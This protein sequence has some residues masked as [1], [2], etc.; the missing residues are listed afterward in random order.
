MFPIKP[1]RTSHL[2]DF[3]GVEYKC[4]RQDD[5]KITEITEVMAR[6]F[7]C[8]LGKCK[9]WN[10]ELGDYYYMRVQYTKNGSRKHP[11][12]NT[13][14]EEEYYF[15]NE[16]EGNEFIKSLQEK[17]D[18]LKRLYYWNIL[19][20]SSSKAGPSNTVLST[21]GFSSSPVGAPV[22]SITTKFITEKK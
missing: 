20:I 21:E 4:D 12:Q 7:L 18:S 15:R 10:R 5:L 8:V 22:A 17:H 11:D 3:L 2:T 16:E 14:Y 1:S 6:R 19:E 9:G 13:F